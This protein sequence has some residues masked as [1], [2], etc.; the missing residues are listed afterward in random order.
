MQPVKA[1]VDC[2]Q[3]LGDTKMTSHRVIME[4][5]EDQPLRIHRLGTT[6]QSPFHHNPEANVRPAA[7]ASSAK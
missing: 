7:F 3:A 1:T 4:S 6:V 5:L 2:L